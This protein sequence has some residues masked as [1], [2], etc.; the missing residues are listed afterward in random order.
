VGELVG[1]AER[2]TV[3]EGQQYWKLDILASSQSRSEWVDEGGWELGVGL[4]V[5]CTV[6]TQSE[7]SLHSCIE[8][9][10]AA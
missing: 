7:N 9:T 2:H 6:H 3:L 4:Y 5:Y 8:L 1:E 10:F